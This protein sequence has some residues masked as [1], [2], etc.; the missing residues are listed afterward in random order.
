[1]SEWQSEVSASPFLKVPPEHHVASNELA[2][3][4]RDKFPVTR[5]HTLVIPRRVVT[6]WWDATTDEQQSIMAL[7]DQIRVDLLDDEVRSYQLPGMPRPDGFNVGFNAGDAAGQT[8]D[9]LHVH[10]IPRHQGDM[11]DPRGGV[12]HVI[13]DKGNYLGGRPETHPETKLE[14]GVGRVVAAGESASLMQWLLLIIEEGRR[15]ATYKP[16]LLTA[17]VDAAIERPAA[18]EEESPAVRIG[19]SELADRIIELYWRQTRPNPFAEGT[20][21]LRQATTPTSRILAAATLLRSMTGVP[22]NAD[23]EQVKSI[24]P[25]EYARCRKSVESALAKQPIPRLQRPGRGASRDGYIPRL[26]DDSEFLPE[27]GALNDDPHITLHPG[28]ASALA[29]NAYVLRQ[30]IQNVWLRD[31]ASINAISSQEAELRSFLFGAQRSSLAPLVAPLHDLANGRC[32]WCDHP[33]E[34]GNV[35][36]DHVIPWSHYP[37][38]DLDN[39]V[40]AD[41]ACNGDK[42]ARLVV[43]ELLGRWVE[44]DVSA[45]AEISAEINWPFDRARSL[46]VG[47]SSYFWQPNGIPV[48]AG[49]HKTITFD[50]LQ[51]TH[52]L[53]VLKVP[54]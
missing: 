6:Q 11:N 45:L 37:S 48:W 28:V 5:G 44:R 38:N 39:L 54:A 2:F 41:R 47:R 53:D 51:R 26:Y 24:H 27:R 4:I 42:S 43:P 33:L 14:E 20:G 13:P 25:I 9:H 18:T 19:L 15:A 22:S 12:R 3:A 30:A 36:V 52:A 17:I 35:E 29:E 31:V 40:L 8:V 7:V 49:R 10:V 16:A 1:M 21:P 32:F 50:D 23:I 34:R 46:R